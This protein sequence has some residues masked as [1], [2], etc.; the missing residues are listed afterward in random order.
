MIPMTRVATAIGKGRIQI[1]KPRRPVH[2][3]ARVIPSNIQF[4]MAS[5]RPPVTVAG[6]GTAF[7]SILDLL[8]ENRRKSNL[9]SPWTC[10]L[11]QS[12]QPSGMKSFLSTILAGCACLLLASV[13]GAEEVQWEPEAN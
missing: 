13:S 3:R 5:L 8:K 4:T 2:E 10:F 9:G 11:E 7:F 1:P 6:C 12:R